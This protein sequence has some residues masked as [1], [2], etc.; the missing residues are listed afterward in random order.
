MCGILM[1]IN[2]DRMI[3]Q[4]ALESL[5]HRGPDAQ[6]IF[7][8]DMLLLGHRRLSI[9]DLSEG[10]NQPMFTDD[11]RFVIIFNGEIY[12]HWELRQERLKEVKFTTVSDTE[13]LLELFRKF[14]A[15]CLQMLNGIFAFV[16]FDQLERT[17]FIARDQFGVK[18]IYYHAENGSFFC[19]SE[20]KALIPLL[21]QTPL[22]ISALQS[23]LTFMWCPGERTPLKNVKK[24]LPGCFMRVEL[25]RPEDFCI[26]QY[27]KLTFPE[28]FE[29]RSLDHWVRDLDEKLT[30]AVERQ[31]LSDAPLGFFLSG[32]LDS[33]LLVALARKLRPKEKLTCY[34]I[35]SGAS[36]DGFAND[37][38]YA[39]KVAKH[40]NVD[41]REIKVDSGVLND[42]DHM[43]W[44]LDE[45]QADPAP[46]NVLR[47]CEVARKD[48][49]KVLI[50]GTGGDDI[51]SGYRRHQALLLDRYLDNLPVIV[52][53]AISSAISKIK[54]SS[55]VVRRLKKL[56]KGMTGDKNERL[57]GYFS[58]QD[59]S[60]IKGLFKQELVNELEPN[61]AHFIKLL[62]EVQHLESDLNKLLYLEIYTFLVDHNLNYTDKAGMA[63]SVEIRVPFLDIEL[64][65][66]ATQIP[67][68]LKLKGKETKYVLRKLAERYLPKDVIYRPKTGFGAPVEHWVR[69]EL[70]DFIEERLSKEELEAQS[71]FDQKRVR[72]IILD[73]KIGKINAS[74]NIWSILAIQSW[75]KLFT[76]Q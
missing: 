39:R 9:Q 2:S 16:V 66:F 28:T 76:N 14:G 12:N 63:H 72:Q 7:S 5:A 13:T 37:L 20:L 44:H 32:G 34:T 74:Y 43:I 18:P 41:L 24:L 6:G 19:S 67:P 65:E 60:F 69:H 54:S 26:Q 45:P 40:L 53:Q 3:F 30:K 15:E 17:L 22:D 23:Y 49:I 1:A 8:R 10:A 36:K 4:K 71:I 57:I 21:D 68:S 70:D 29:K 64:V 47:I 50:S 56:T 38:D 73:N 58:W 52:R 46:L 62:N 51:F 59:F 27:Y 61:N 33:S 25:D 48:G 75:K 55:A 31:L 35:D 11:Q 42:F